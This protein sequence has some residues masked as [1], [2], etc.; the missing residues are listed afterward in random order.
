M[1]AAR[2]QEGK[3]MEPKQ[4]L[5]YAVKNNAKFLDMRFVDLPGVWQHVSFPIGQLSGDSFT[6]GFGIDGSSIRGWASIHESDMLLIPD[7]STFVMDPFT[8]VPT[9]GMIADIIDP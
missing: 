9:L 5:E 8:E 1:W 7:P 3:R 2:P 6:E 4:V